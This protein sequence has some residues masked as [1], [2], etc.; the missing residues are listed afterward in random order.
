MRTQA[1]PSVLG[2]RSFKLVAPGIEA[3]TTALGARPHVIRPKRH[4]GVLVFYVG[5]E[6]VV[7]R[8]PIRHPGNQGTDWFRKS[9]RKHGQRTLTAAARRARF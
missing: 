2:R 7:R 8:G 1:I 9:I 3:R 4:G 5:G 6:K